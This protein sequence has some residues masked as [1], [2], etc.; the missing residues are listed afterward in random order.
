MK[1]SKIKNLSVLLISTFLGAAGQFMFKFSFLGIGLEHLVVYLIFGLLLYGLSTV[2]YFYVLSRA[3][4]TWVY[5]I[6]GL[7]YIF[8]VIM[9]NFI[10][11]VPPLRWV[12]VIVITIG[13]AL[14][15]LS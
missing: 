3:H 6:G 9:A 15:G 10:E 13:V 11:V 7:A 5:G 14:I 1:E 8:A 4:L 12:G 2:F